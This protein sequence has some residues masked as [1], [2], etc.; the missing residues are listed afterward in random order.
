MGYWFLSR[1]SGELLMSTVPHL[2]VNSPDVRNKY[3]LGNMFWLGI[4]SGLVYF[5]ASTTVEL[6]LVAAMLVP[7]RVRTGY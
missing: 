7:S 6:V 2:T 1:A 4:F 5:T 3:V